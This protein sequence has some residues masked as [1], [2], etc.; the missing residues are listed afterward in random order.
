MAPGVAEKVAAG[1]EVAV[2]V[3]YPRD[4][5][6]SD[7]K[8]RIL[9]PSAT[10]ISI[11][12]GPPTDVTPAPASTRRAA[13]AEARSYPA[14]LAVDQDDAVRLV[15]AAQTGSIYLGLLGDTTKVA[16]SPGVDYDNLWP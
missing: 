14:T 7:Q 3:T 15:H 12:T 6:P 16:P 2:F 1:D 10:V 4:A 8:T 5:S 9:L 11:T 13:R